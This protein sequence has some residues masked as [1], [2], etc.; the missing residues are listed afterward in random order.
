MSWN[1]YGNA[2]RARAAQFRHRYLVVVSGD[3]DWALKTSRQLLGTLETIWISDSPATSTSVVTNKDSRTFLGREFQSVVYDAEAGINPDSLGIVSGTIT[4][5]GLLV[6]V[7]PGTRSV[8]VPDD[9]KANALNK[10]GAAPISKSPNRPYYLERCLRRLAEPGLAIHICQHQAPVPVADLP[11]PDQHSREEDGKIKTPAVTSDQE[12]AIAAVLK[13]VTGQRKRPTVLISD[14]G[15]GKSATLGLAAGI[16]LGRGLAHIIVTG[17]SRKSVESVFRHA[18]EVTNGSSPKLQWRTVTDLIDHYPGCDLLLI[19]E[20]ASIPL[21]QLTK[22]LQHYSRI[23][24]ATTVHGYEGTG[25][26]FMLRFNRILDKQTRGWRKFRLVQPIRWSEHDPLERA[27]NRLLMLDA[28]LPTLP[29][30]AIQ[31]SAPNANECRIEWVDQATLVDDE[32][33]LREIFSLLVLAHYKTRPGDLKQLLNNPAI[34][35]CRMVYDYQR[36]HVTTGVAVI[37]TEGELAPSMGLQLLRGECRPAG[38]VLPEILSSQLGLADSVT[39]KMGRI[40]R[41]VI[42]PEWQRNGLGSAMLKF[43]CQHEEQR[44]DLIGANFS[45]SAELARF[46]QHCGFAPVRIGL[47]QIPHSG[48]NS[49]VYLRPRTNPGNSF[50]ELARKSFSR[51]FPD[52]LK[53]VL[54]N[55]DP[56]IVNAICANNVDL[57]PDPD[58]CDLTEATSFCYG[59]R[60]AESIPTALTRLAF[61]GLVREKLE[62]SGLVIERVLQ[63]KPW[64]RCQNLEGNQ[65]RTEGSLRLQRS[66]SGLLEQCHKE[67]LQQSALYQSRCVGTSGVANRNSADRA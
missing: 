30:S 37:V 61:A 60:P 25:R 23:A 18:A 28:E 4:G 24:M 56:D 46:W 17:H 8:L 53:S 2:L 67:F 44:F 58:R 38:H 54:R 16:L 33:L 47:T 14:R 22:L 29:S 62:D 1:A 35:I 51:N 21:G 57:H 26:G 10:T 9:P 45:V 31:C 66:F 49:V 52:Q 50:C 11:M 27:I 15:R 19:D 42:H 32:P 63:G 64:A 41:I 5:G 34:R 3:R 6:L 20:A 7:N 55:F 36:S 59:C 12:S 39:L 40:M 13:V 48:A 43:I 65:G